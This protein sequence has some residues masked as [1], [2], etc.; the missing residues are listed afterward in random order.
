MSRELAENE[1]KLEV[2]LVWSVTFLFLL[3]LS[4][5]FSS[6]HDPE[7][8]AGAETQVAV[9]KRQ[10][11]AAPPTLRIRVDRHGTL[12]VEGLD[13]NNPDVGALGGKLEGLDSTLVIVSPDPDVPYAI[14]A[15]LLRLIRDSGHAT[16]LDTSTN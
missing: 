3:L 2:D 14:T 6:V 16:A 5:T 13:L 9:A 7:R 8:A 10:A 1:Q 15:P 11:E 4:A 12:W